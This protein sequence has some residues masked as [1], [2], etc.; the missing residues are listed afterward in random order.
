MKDQFLLNP[1][2]AYLNFG[3]FGA[4]AKPV[5]E[6]YQKYQLELETEPVQFIAV[7]STR[8]LKASRKALG[9]YIHCHEDDIIF[10][11]NPSY[12]INIITKSLKLNPGDEILSTDLEYGAMDKTW[13]HY[14]KQ[15]GTNYIRQPISL[16]LTSK[17]QILADFRKGLTPK[18]KV[19]FLGQITSAT[20]LILPVKEICDMAKEKGLLTIVDGAHVPGHIPLDLR[21]LKADIYTGA[22]HKWMM[23]PKGCS[24]LYVNKDNQSWIDP[25]VVSWGYDSAAPSPS[26][27]QDYHELQGTRD[28]S[29]FLTVPKALEFMKTHHWEQK[30]ADCRKLVREN[31]KR[32]CD[33]LNTKP[34]AP[35]T[36]EFIGQMISIPVRTKEPEQLQ[37]LLFT[38]YKVEV[39]IMRHGENTYLR[40]SI[41]AF[42]TQKDLDRL[43]NALETILKTTALI[44][45]Q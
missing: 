9:D 32:F 40:Y 28:I 44:H 29:A 37:R 11:P 5:F 13:S 16:P 2:I 18:T 23:T 30:S 34:L 26:Q 38:D 22:C 7:N 1:D 3:S 8:Y 17:E 45:L 43:Y 41:Q 19:I 35:V 31:V 15:T 4:C 20:A 42:N 27:F 39:P 36:E 25:L 21:D 10:T 24:F 33:L 14:C 12:A 6:E